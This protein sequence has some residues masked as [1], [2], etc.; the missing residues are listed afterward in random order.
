M[1]FDVETI[2]KATVE[3]GRTFPPMLRF[4]VETINKA[5]INWDIAW[6]AQLR[7]DVET[8]NKATQIISN[9]IMFSCGLM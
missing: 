7:F 2:N 3:G 9:N 6:V 1:R 4:D 5:T 8:I